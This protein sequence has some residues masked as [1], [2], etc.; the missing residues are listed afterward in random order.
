M[1]RR[2]RWL[3]ITPDEFLALMGAIRNRVVQVVLEDRDGI[4]LIPA[5]EWQP[6]DVQYDFSRRLFMIR[7]T[8]PSFDEVPEGNDTPFGGMVRVMAL[9]V[10]SVYERLAR[11]IS[12]RDAIIHD[13]L[14][15]LAGRGS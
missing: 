7:V 11:C 13:L 14:E 1:N 3:G 9:P 8:H 12:E 4:P 5:S 6:H 15:Q 10:E 2:W